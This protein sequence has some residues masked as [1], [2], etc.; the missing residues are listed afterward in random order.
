MTKQRQIILQELRMFPGHPTT[1]EL[2]DRVRNIL[3]HISLA[4]VYRNLEILSNAGIIAKIEVSGRQKRFDS[5]LHQHDHV[6]C[7]RCSKIDNI[8][9]D[10]K[11]RLNI[12]PETAKGYEIDSYRMELKGICPECLNKTK[13]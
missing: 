3:S 1:D 4:T 10:A 5:K 12:T 13:R 8:E 9:L 11:P 2:Y 7:I 6:F